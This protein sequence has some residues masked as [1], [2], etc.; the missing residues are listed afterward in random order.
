MN[1]SR[2]FLIAGSAYLLVG[3]GFGMYMGPTQ[4]F[5]FAP[6]HAHINL[7]GF[8]LMTLFGVAYRVMPELAGNSLAKAHFWLHQIGV[9]ILLVLLFL[10]IRGGES[11]EASIGPVMALPELAVFIGIACY[12]LNLYKNAK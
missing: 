10:M 4:D 2:N 9:L 11:A 1:I 12:A 8:V 6:L 7:L 3:I 5:K